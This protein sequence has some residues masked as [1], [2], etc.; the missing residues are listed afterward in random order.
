MTGSPVEGAGR[1]T[2][3]AGFVTES[4]SCDGSLRRHN[5][6]STRRAALFLCFGLVFFSVC[7]CVCM[8]AC[9]YVLFG[10]A[11]RVCVTACARNVSASAAAVG[12]VDANDD[13]QRLPKLTVYF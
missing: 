9:V 7:V 8:C 4:S 13:N 3:L 11:A 5:G 1:S 6:E 2:V 10:S 12:G